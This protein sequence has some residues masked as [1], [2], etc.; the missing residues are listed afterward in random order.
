MIILI[1]FCSQNAFQ[2][3][4]S[5]LRG[6]FGG[7]ERKGLWLSGG[8][9]EHLSINTFE[10]LC[11]FSFLPVFGIELVSPNRSFNIRTPENQF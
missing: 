3:L 11:D 10:H 6:R 9:W 4:I 2:A 7:E 8:S 1:I 5:V